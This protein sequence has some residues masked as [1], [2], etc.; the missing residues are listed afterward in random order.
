[1]AL[2]PSQEHRSILHTVTILNSTP[3]EQFTALVDSG[4]S[5]SFNSASF[6][7]GRLPLEILDHP[8]ELMLFDGR[9]TAPVTHA[10]FLEVSSSVTAR[11]A[12]CFLV[13]E[14]PSDTSMVL[15]MDFL[16]SIN[17]DID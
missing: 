7:S 14:L 15:G 8:M 10:V 2:K 13:T 3:A 12:M 11:N 16:H 5:D 6:L 1:M 9:K 17:P 4:A